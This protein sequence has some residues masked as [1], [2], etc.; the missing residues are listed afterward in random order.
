MS[1]KSAEQMSE[2]FSLL[3]RDKAKVYCET[4][5]YLIGLKK[6]LRVELRKMMLAKA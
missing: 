1:V 4:G 2:D 6:E 3:F 5:D